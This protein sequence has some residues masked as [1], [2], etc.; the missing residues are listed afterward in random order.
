MRIF[1]SY[2][3]QICKKWLTGEKMKSEDLI[4]I[5]NEMFFIV[6]LIL[7]I[8][9]SLAISLAILH[10]FLIIRVGDLDTRTYEEATKIFLN[11]NLYIFFALLIQF[12]FSM[13]V[14]TMLTLLYSHKIAC[15]V[16]RL[17]QVLNQYL[18][19]GKPGQIKFRENDFLPGVAAG[20]NGFFA[21]FSERKKLILRLSELEEDFAHNPSSKS[22]QQEIKNILSQIN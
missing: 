5:R 18:E 4:P 15:P 17:K 6:K 11:L 8:L 20:F 19:H 22:V 21:W 10:V 3:I 14:V 1:L 16:Y 9:L 7:V 13:I 12:C 2:A